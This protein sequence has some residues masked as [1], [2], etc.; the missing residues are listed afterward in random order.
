MKYVEGHTRTQVDL[1][2]T[3]IR[4]RL[5]T[6]YASLDMN[7]SDRKLFLAFTDITNVH[8]EPELLVSKER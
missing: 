5:S 4:H 1:N 6:I 7:P 2:A 3:K 8:S